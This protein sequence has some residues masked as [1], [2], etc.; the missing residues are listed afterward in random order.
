MSAGTGVSHSEY[1]KNQD[2]EVK[3]LQIWLF[4]NQRN[5]KPRYDQITLDKAKMKN[6]LL[7]ILS[8]KPTDEGVWIHQN[9]WFSMGELDAGFEEEYQLHSEKNGV[10]AFVLEGAVSIDGQPLEKRDGFGVW[11]T[12][13][14]NVKADKDARLLLMEVPMTLS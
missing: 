7:Q 10:Y 4:P 13:K 5:V 6:N 9:A 14:I 1:N 11:D 2:Q 12:Q 8:P 3:F